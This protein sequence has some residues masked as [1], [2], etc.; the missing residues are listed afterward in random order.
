MGIGENALEVQN[1]AG[2]KLK[3]CVKFDS[4]GPR[5]GVLAWIKISD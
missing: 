4:V 3:A 5:P 1:N 2:V